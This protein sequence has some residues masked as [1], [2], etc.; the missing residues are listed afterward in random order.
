MDIYGFASCA[1]HL[2]GVGLIHAVVGDLITGFVVFL[3]HGIISEFQPEGQDEAGI[4]WVAL[5]VLA[6]IN[7]FQSLLE[8]TNGILRVL[9]VP[10]DPGLVYR[11]V[12]VAQT[13][14]GDGEG[15][16]HAVG[17]L[18]FISLIGVVFCVFVGHLIPV[19]ARGDFEDGI[20]IPTGS[21]VGRIQIIKSICFV[22]VLVF[23]QVVLYLIVPHH[24][25]HHIEVVNVFDTVTLRNILHRIPH[26]LGSLIAQGYS[27]IS[28]AFF[29]RLIGMGV[30][31]GEGH[32]LPVEVVAVVQP[33]LL[34]E[35][36]DGLARAAV[37]HRCGVVSLFVPL[38]FI[39]GEAPFLQQGVAVR[40]A[41]LVKPGQAGDLDVPEVT[42]IL[43]DDNFLLYCFRYSSL[44]YRSRI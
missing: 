44:V 12:D 37:D 41:A 11:Q 10:V 18:S 43:R 36:R 42:I 34:N 35:D 31:Y 5:I 22:A 1:A 39:R 26:T 30:V 29:Q 27:V 25:L 38:S 21:P 24:G 9:S 13:A 17:V 23:F 2:N 14:V 7:G 16:I 32:R 3:V 8:P 40:V 6:I 33:H 4:C 28:L 19:V 20:R 15:S